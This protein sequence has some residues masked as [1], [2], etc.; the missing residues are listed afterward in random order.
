MKTK[1]QKRAE[2]HWKEAAEY[3]EK[4]N[5]VD[6]FP[7]FPSTTDK[8]LRAVRTYHHLMRLIFLR[9]KHLYI[10]ILDAVEDDNSYISFTLL[11]AYWETVAML[12]YAYIVA[13]N[14]LKKGK[15]D[16]LAE[17]TIKH[18]LGGRKYPSDEMLAEKGYKREDFTQTNLCTWMDTVDKH[19]SKEVA[20]EKNFSHLRE[21][22]DEFVAEAGHSTFLGLSICEER[23][24]SGS[25]TPLVNKTSC[26]E[27]DLMTLNNLHLVTT[28]FFYYWELFQTDIDSQLKLVTA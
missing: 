1:Q 16:E 20:G 2:E 8:N 26:F 22:Y 4:F 21:L 14:Y 7:A 12:G 10:G 17:W 28:Y 9:A 18:S 27:D 23:R 24:K 25:L 6:S 5:S 19:F 3:K 11:K 13:K 15:F